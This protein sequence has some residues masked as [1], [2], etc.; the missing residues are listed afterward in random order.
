[1]LEAARQRGAPRAASWQVG[2]P[3]VALRIAAFQP[4]PTVGADAG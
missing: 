4:L 3:S 1:M 2:N